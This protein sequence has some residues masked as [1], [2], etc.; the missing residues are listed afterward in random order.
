MITIM[1]HPTSPRPSHFLLTF[2]RPMSCES[3]SCKIWIIQASVKKLYH[4]P[5]T[6]QAPLWKILLGHF[7]FLVPLS[8]LLCVCVSVFVLKVCT[9]LCI[10]CAFL[11]AKE[12]K[13]VLPPPFPPPLS[14]FCEKRDF[15]TNGH[16]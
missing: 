1:I 16:I 6:K 13:F 7:R 12:E 8:V 14:L 5:R 3:A 10:I 2:C 4:Q 11:T 9:Y 15:A